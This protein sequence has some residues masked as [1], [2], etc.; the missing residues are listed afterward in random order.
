MKILNLSNYSISFI[1]V[2]SL[3]LHISIYAVANTSLAYWRYDNL[4]VHAAVELSGGLIAF[5]VAFLLLKL[6]KLQIGTSYNII[7]AAALIGMGLFDITHALMPSG[8]A[9]VWFHSLATLSGG[10]IFSL[11]WLPKNVIS[12]YQQH[13]PLFVS[14]TSLSIIIFSVTNFSLLPSMLNTEGFTMSAEFINAVGGSLLL[15]SALKLYLSY[16]K[17]RKPDDLLFILH[18]FMFGAA[19]IM[20]EQSTLWDVSWWGWHVLRLL[21]YAVAL[22]FALGSEAAIHLL[23]LVERDNYKYDNQRQRK[24]LELQNEIL[25]KSEAGQ[26]AIIDN[27]TDPLLIIDQQGVIKR[28]TPSAEIVFGYEASEVLGLDIN[29]LV[30]DEI[31]LNEI[32]TNQEQSKSIWR[33]R[34]LKAKDKNGKLFLTEL[35]MA[36]FIMDDD[37]HFIG[38]IRDITE[39]QKT[40]KAMEEAKHQAEHANYAKS[41]FLAN[42]S[43]EIRTPLNG[44]YGNLQLIAE[45]QTDAY[46]ESLLKN[47]ILSAKS[48]T[49]IINDILDFSK[50]E[51]GKLEI[52]NA[53]FQLSDITELIIAEHKEI[54]HSKGISLECEIEKN[55]ANNWLGDAIRVRQILLNLVSNAI[56]FTSKGK[57]LIKVERDNIKG[58]VITVSDTGIGMDNKGLASLFER[59]IQADSSTTRRFGGTGLGMAITYNLIK[60]MNGQIDVQSQIG[61]GSTFTVILSM[62]ALDN[63]KANTKDIDKAEIP[64][65]NGKTLLVAEDNPINWMVI[66]NMLIRTEAEVI[67]A[68][69]GEE[70]I[71]LFS[72]NKPDLI[73]MDI[74]MPVLDGLSACKAILEQ[75]PSAKIIAVT[76][77]VMN[78]DVKKC[79]ANGF[80]D[81]IAKPIELQDLMFKLTKNFCNAK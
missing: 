1:I 20:F 12:R 53:P 18:C 39:R 75:D 11:I 30:L 79:L 68:N 64:N 2:L 31:P 48:L 33:K 5:L 27:I 80:I 81:H 17:N 40:L 3:L 9:F 7:I 4:V 36:E 51:A 72:E 19:A 73:L 46:C 66:S 69:N 55:S 78:N 32:T 61:E 6:E 23:T 8:N 74:Q 76:A 47:A 62:K 35:T 42:M 13:L 34:E 70:A 43:H 15:L 21:A 77:N 26:R 28:F 65:L 41:E 63:C 49:T 54:A 59:F 58:L 37:I 45:Y 24:Q 52:T 38:L 29:L 57:V 25:R 44:I 22:Y 60:L 16:R 50:I 14:I 56:K 71:E 10:V 67:H